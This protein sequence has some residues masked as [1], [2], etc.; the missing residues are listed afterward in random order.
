MPE[1]HQLSM[2]SRAANI[3]DCQMV[4][5]ADV[6]RA[7]HRRKPEQAQTGQTT[8]RSAGASRKEATSKSA[9]AS[10]K[11]ATR[12]SCRAELESRAGKQS[13]KA[14]LESRAGKQSWKAELESRAGKQKRGCRASGASRK[15]PPGRLLTRERK[16][17]RVKDHQGQDYVAQVLGL[18]GEEDELAQALS[19]QGLSMT[20][21]HA[22]LTTMSLVASWH[23]MR[24][25][26][27]QMARSLGP[28]VVGR[29]I[30]TRCSVAGVVLRAA[31][32]L[33]AGR[34][35]LNP[36]MKIMKVEHGS[37]LSRS[38]LLG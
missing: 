16:A 10:R 29:E 23:A 33:P 28:V 19:L 3:T 24:S 9:G 15:E 17:A 22:T 18:V 14:E 2:H 35:I 27:K 8:G 31:C 1:L 7:G 34:S 36:E 32:A 5:A 12:Q 37:S 13:W 20:M 38:W 4:P 11:E 26:M 6:G 25:S 21:V 30:M